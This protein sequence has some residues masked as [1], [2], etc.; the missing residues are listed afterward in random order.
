M[1]SLI[2]LSNLL[3]FYCFYFSSARIGA[4]RSTKVE[5]YIGDHRSTSLAVGI[6]SMIISLVFSV[7]VYGEGA[8]T[9]LFFVLLST[10]ASLVI[11]ITPLRVL[12]FKW[13]SV[14]LIFC[15]ILEKLFV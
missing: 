10:I 2:I 1:T 6:V 3:G 11:L 13:L 14:I 15:F 4:K 8:G 12:N 9:L 7:R 5:H